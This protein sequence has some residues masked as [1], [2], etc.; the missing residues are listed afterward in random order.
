MAQGVGKGKR[1]QQKAYSGSGMKSQ[2][3]ETEKEHSNGLRGNQY[4]TSSA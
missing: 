3:K 4:N 2:G 1:T